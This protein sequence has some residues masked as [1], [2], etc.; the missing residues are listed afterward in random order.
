MEKRTILFVTLAIA[1]IATLDLLLLLVSGPENAARI[2]PRNP[3]KTLT[4]DAAIIV[5][6]IGAQL[7]L[8]YKQR[9][10][11]IRLL[12]YAFTLAAVFAFA[13]VLVNLMMIGIR[14]H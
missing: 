13:L 14:G 6:G 9:S 10:R 12:A 1:S 3:S 4:I 8:R 2:A 11:R 5:I 7:W